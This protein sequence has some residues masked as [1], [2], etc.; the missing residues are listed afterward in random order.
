MKMNW[1]PSACEHAT[2]VSYRGPGWETSLGQVVF[3]L[4]I[5]CRLVYFS[6]ICIFRKTHECQNWKTSGNLPNGDAYVDLLPEFFFGIPIT[7]R[8]KIEHT[9]NLAFSL[10]QAPHTQERLCTNC[11]CL[12]RTSRH[13]LLLPDFGS[14]HEVL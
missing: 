7:I 1:G 10:F 6:V 13:V 11:S 2:N 14:K 9:T 5:L 12:W 3:I 4:L 8:S